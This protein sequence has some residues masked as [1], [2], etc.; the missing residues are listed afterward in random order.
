MST[1]DQIQKLVRKEKLTKVRH[2]VSQLSSTDIPI[3]ILIE[4]L[5]SLLDLLLAIGVSHLSSHHG[6]ELW[7]VN[8]TVTIR[9]FT[10]SMI[11]C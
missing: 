9:L 3:S 5:E 10:K 11:R 2:D 8:C 6:K 4:Y 1:K 7:E